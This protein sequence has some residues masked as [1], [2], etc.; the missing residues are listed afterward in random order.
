MQCADS[1]HLAVAYL[2]GV[3]FVVGFGDGDNIKKGTFGGCVHVST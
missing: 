1:I 2:H 3:L